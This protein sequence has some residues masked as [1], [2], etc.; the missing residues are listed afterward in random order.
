RLADLRAAA[1]DRRGFELQP[2][3]A[4][5]FHLGAQPQEAIR[6]DRFDSPEVDRV[7]SE[8]VRRMAPSATEPDASDEQVESAAQLP[9]EV[10]VIPAVFSP[11][12]ANR[13][14]RQG[15]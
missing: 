15:A 8:E 7:A 10:C 14:K 2:R 9:E 6:L 1:G 12:S 4:R 11:D 3:A 13:A 5:H